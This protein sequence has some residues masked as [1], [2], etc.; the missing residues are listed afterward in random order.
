MKHVF[1]RYSVSPIK[2]KAQV[3]NVK[4]DFGST[5]VVDPVLLD[6]NLKA[7]KMTNVIGGTAEQLNAYNRFVKY[8]EDLIVRR[9]NSAA[10]VAMAPPSIKE[11]Q[12]ITAFP[13][14]SPGIDVD[15]ILSILDNVKPPLITDDHRRKLKLLKDISV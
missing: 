13:K 3:E 4:S 12:L 6:N 8:L 2:R 1:P 11:I 15:V 7:L 5:T 10:A 14:E 9:D